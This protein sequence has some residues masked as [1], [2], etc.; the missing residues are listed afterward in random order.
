MH[1]G[2]DWRTAAWPEQHSGAHGMILVHSWIVSTRRSLHFATAIGA[3]VVAAQPTQNA[4][5]MEQVAAGQAMHNQH[6]VL[7]VGHVKADGA[8]RAVGQWFVHV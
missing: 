5:L 2:G 8:V 3:D 4:V 1:I 6:L 7:I